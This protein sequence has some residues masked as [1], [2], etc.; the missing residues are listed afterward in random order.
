[1]KKNILSLLMLLC[2][3]PGC[4]KK[5][6]RKGLK[7]E[8]HSSVQPV[9]QN[10]D[11]ALFDEDIEDFILDEK[12]EKN[13]FSEPLIETENEYLEESDDF[14]FEEEEPVS[15]NEQKNKLKTT[16]YA[17]NQY[18]LAPDQKAGLELNIKQIKSSLSSNPSCQFI[19][20]GH[21]CSSAGSDSY[22]L[23]LSNRRGAAYKKYLVENN[24]PAEAL[25]MVGRGSEMPI[26]P[27][28]NQEEQA[29]NR[30]VEIYSTSQHKTV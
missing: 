25:K 9:T 17:F 20:E 3:M 23:A 1:M 24:I 22:N 10:L 30:R 11:Q 16:Y 27:M 18:S 19:I 5:I 2:I 4:K 7:P 13:P 29:P 12:N 21:A 26:V 8:S 15:L 28:G 6:S 14:E